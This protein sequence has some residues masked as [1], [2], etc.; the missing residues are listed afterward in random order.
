MLWLLFFLLFAKPVF[1][2]DSAD[3]YNKYRTD[4]LF[5]RDLYQQDYRDYLNKKDVYSQFGTVTAEKDKI[6]ATKNVLISQNLMLKTYLMALRV[7]LVD[8]PE[9]Q[10]DLQKFEDWLSTQNQVI[11]QLNVTQDIKNWT[12]TF[13]N[14]YVSIQTKLFTGLIQGQINRRLKTIADIKKLA[15]EAKVEWS[16]NYSEKETKIYEEFAQAL[17]NTQRNQRNNRFSDF[18]SDSK[19]NLDTADTQIKGL[20]SDL[21][22]TI[23]K[24]NL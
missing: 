8:S 23:I 20:I 19:T 15:Q 7:T 13:Q 14:Q 3:L 12:L 24:N 17:K 2:Q 21:K 18:Y 22:S 9:N 6:I 10:N 5:Q 16:S 1:A 11:P 4:Y